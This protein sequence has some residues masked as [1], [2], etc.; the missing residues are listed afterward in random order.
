MLVNWLAGDMIRAFFAF[1]PLV[2]VLT[3]CCTQKAIQLAKYFVLHEASCPIIE[4]IKKNSRTIPLPPQA[5]MPRYEYRSQG[6]QKAR[7]VARHAMPPPAVISP[8]HQTKPMIC[9]VCCNNAVVH[10]S[11][12]ILDVRLP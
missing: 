9:Y 2:L 11:Y 7:M 4:A 8:P 6:G 10:V 1:V 5:S 12:R 3:P